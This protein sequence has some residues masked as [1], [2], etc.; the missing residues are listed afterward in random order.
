MKLCLPQSARSLSRSLAL[1]LPL[2]ALG[3]F[4]LIETLNHRLFADGPA[5][6]L[7]FLHQYPLAA[8][9]DYFIILLTLIPAVLLRRRLFYS[10]LISVV[11][12]AGGFANGFILTKRTTPLTAPDVAMLKTGIHTMPNYLPV[13]AI[14]LLFLCILLVLAGLVLL[15]LRGPQSQLPRRDRLRRGGAAILAV[16]ILLG[17]SLAAG[18][19]TGQISSDFYNLPTVYRNYGFP[20]CFL[21]TLLNRGIDRPAGYSKSYMNRI[22]EQIPEETGGEADVNILFVQLESLLDPDNVLGLSLTEDA[23]PNFHALETGYASGS[24]TVPVLGASTANTEFEVLT[25]MRC[26]FFGPGEYPYKSKGRHIPIDSLASGLGDLGYTAHAIHNNSTTFY[27]RDAV[28]QNFGFDTYTGLEYMPAT[29]KTPNGWATDGVLTSQILQAMDSTEDASDFVFTVTVQCHGSYPADPLPEEQRIGVTECPA[30]MDPDAVTY[31]V[32]QL[33]E[34]DRFVGELIAELED[35]D[36]PTVVVFYGDHQPSLN[37]TNQDLLDGTLFQTDYVIW[38]NL[39]LPAKDEDLPTYQLAAEVLDRLDKDGGPLFR[40]HSANRESLSY[41]RDLQAIQYDLLYGSQYLCGSD[42]PEASELQ[43]GV[44]PIEMHVIAESPKGYMITGENFTPFCQVVQG[45]D[46]LETVFYHEWL[47]EVLIDP[48][49]ADTDS[50]TIQVIDKYR[51]T[52]S[53]IDD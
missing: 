28:Y 1:R 31:Y 41:T 52:L 7:R 30:D 17:A 21:Q 45:E 16:A 40:Y 27:S 39:G 15:F 43:L 38:D 5:S 44:V 24:L 6:F 49:D 46:L 11:W 8:L 12:L 29:E 47:L 42:K 33:W 36:E 50:W 14:V 23:L 53:E 13:W 34:T 10:L 37:Q 51:E 19:A 18:N 48:E 32:N 3:L 35:R 26:R 22:A 2:I 4:L 9:A 20:Y 25:G